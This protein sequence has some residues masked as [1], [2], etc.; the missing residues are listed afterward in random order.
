MDT[1]A[2]TLAKYC[3]ATPRVLLTRKLRV[4]QR[5]SAPLYHLRGDYELIFACNRS[6]WCVEAQTMTSADDESPSLSSLPKVKAAAL[7]FEEKVFTKT[8][9]LSRREQWARKIDFLVACVGFSVGLGNVWRFPFLCYKNGGGQGLVNGRVNGECRGLANAH[10]AIYPQGAVSHPLRTGRGGWWNTHVLPGG[11][12]GPVYVG[13]RC[14][15]LEDRTFDARRKVLS[16]SAGV[17]EPGS[18]KWDLALCLLLAWVIVYFCIWKGIRS[19]GKVMYFTATAPYLL[20]FVLLV[21]GVT[22][23]G[24]AEGLKYYLLPD[25]Q[26]L[27]DPQVW[28]D[29]GTQIF[30]S[31]SISLG[32]L[33]ALGSYN[34]FHHNSFRDSLWFAGINTFTSFLAGFVI[35]SIL[36]F[37]AHRQN[38]QVSDVAESGPGLA[39]IA[40]PEALAQ[41]PIGPLWSV[42][43]FL[44]IVLLGID[45]QFVGVEGFVTA[46]VDRFPRQL[47]QGRRKELFIAGVC[48]VCYLI[49][50]SMVTEGGMYVFQLFDYYSSSRVVLIVAFFECI[51]VAYMYGVNRFYDNIEM[52]FGFRIGPWMKICWMFCTPVYT[53]AIF[54]LG[55]VLYSELS[56]KRKMVTY[57]YPPWAIGIGWMLLSVSVMFI[58]IFM[59]YRMLTTPGTFL[60]R[61]KHLLKPRLRKH[62]LRSREDL[63]HIVLED[64]DDFYATDKKDHSPE[65]SEDHRIPQQHCW[66]QHSSDDNTA[67]DE[68]IVQSDVRQTHQEGDDHQPLSGTA[69]VANHSAGKVR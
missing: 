55:C 66:Q 17:G 58:P 47:R 18:V 65:L 62:Q 27:K 6:V 69:S 39:F 8:P 60:Q 34:K 37:M 4:P 10:L 29:A 68:L 56:Y 3:A 16:L 2:V 57:E 46:A 38:I 44:M 41:L 67:M 9:K 36:G 35:F 7:T 12:L 48:V 64:Y 53:L 21:R 31:Y 49:G 61:I 63:S 45:S 24:A 11:R 13:R 20:M 1:A 5:L 28:A 40:Y 51:T 15:H 30:F 43:F 50:L 26:R 54:I 59:T 14:R 19:S 32:T 25:W 23:E 33:T 22:L 42:M 52:M